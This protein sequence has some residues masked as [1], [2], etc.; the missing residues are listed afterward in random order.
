MPFCF[1]FSLSVFLIFSFFV[2][3]LFFCRSP[4]TPSLFLF[5]FVLSLRLIVFRLFLVSPFS[6]LCSL[7]FFPWW[8]NLLLCYFVSAG[9]PPR[10]PCEPKVCVS[11][12]RAVFFL[13]SL[14]MAY[15]ILSSLPSLF[16]FRFGHR[17]FLPVFFLWVLCCFLGF[18]FCCDLLS[19]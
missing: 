19:V 15:F 18:G 10:A 12:L 5:S 6:L 4:C 9:Y 3:P 7:P 13:A 2:F 14:M 11:P 8:L 16:R 17:L 1:P